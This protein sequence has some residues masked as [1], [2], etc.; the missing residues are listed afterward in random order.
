MI[1]YISKPVMESGTVKFKAQ[2]SDQQYSWGTVNVRL[3]NPS[4]AGPFKR[5]EGMHAMPGPKVTRFGP[6]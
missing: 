5:P 4:L 2:A 1:G 6:G 3:D